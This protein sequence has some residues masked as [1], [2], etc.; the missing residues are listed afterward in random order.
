MNKDKKFLLEESDTFCMLPW[1]HLYVNTT[2]DVYSCCTAKYEYPVGHTGK[3][4]IEEIW[5]SEEIKQ[6]RKE[7]LSGVKSK[8]CENCYMHAS[9][10]PKGKMSFRYWANEKF[11]DFIDLIDFTD[12][13]GHLS[14]MDLKHFDV[15][16]SNIC[17]FKCRTCGDWFSSSWAKESK[18]HF[19]KDRQDYKVFL[20]ASE[21]NQE[22]LDQFKPYLPNMKIIYF[23]GGEPLIA[24]EHY[25]TLDYLIEQNA[26]D[27]V[28]LWY[29]SNASKLI[30]KNKHVIDYWKKFK[31]ISF[32]ASIDTWGT[33]AEY[34]RHGTNW[35]RIVKNLLKIKKECPHVEI[36]YNSVIGM[37]NCLTITDFLESMEE[38]GIFDPFKSNPSFYRQLN[39]EW[40]SAKILPLD[41]RLKGIE[42]INQYIEKKQLPDTVSLNHRLQEIK[43]YMSQPQDESE[44]L[45]RNLKHYVSMIDKIRNESFV[46]AFP[47]LREWYENL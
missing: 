3:N 17:N 34:M 32:C 10:D 21:D 36:G 14:K 24:D 15:R 27:D 25:D 8:Q 42:K 37:W 30:Y 47:E 40:Q 16:W 4:K 1:V 29:N 7:M 9:T 46:K 35:K 5:N 18:M 19:Y 13:D 28:L 41:L 2:G 26:T 38:E 39:P 6:L 12:D 33:R 31:N 45:K 43:S 20:K 11:G 23:A 22:L 44:E